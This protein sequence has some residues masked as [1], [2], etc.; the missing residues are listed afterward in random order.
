MLHLSAE[1]IYGTRHVLGTALFFRLAG[2]NVERGPERE[3]IA[4]YERGCW[5]A[6][7]SHYSRLDFPAPVIVS[8]ERADG[9]MSC[10][11]G[12]FSHV[13]VLDGCAQA[14]GRVLA[15]CRDECAEWELADAQSGQGR[16]S[17]LVLDSRDPA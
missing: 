11:V 17:V 13:A 14:D 8:V 15:R 2:M 3:R 7:N 10:K 9:A 12:E 4:R 5:V 6:R 16:W 1:T